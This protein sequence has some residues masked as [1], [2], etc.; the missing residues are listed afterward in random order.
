M[1]NDYRCRI[2]GEDE[3]RKQR[4]QKIIMDKAIVP[5]SW[6]FTYVTKGRV[7]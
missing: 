5:L 6:T 2:I 1:K 7:R 4:N 3:A